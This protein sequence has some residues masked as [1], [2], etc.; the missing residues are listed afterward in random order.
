MAVGLL[1]LD[2]LPDPPDYGGEL[3]LVVE[4]LGVGRVGD[5]L[6]RPDHG[7]RHPAVEGG[8]LV[9]LVRYR[10]VQPAE[11]VLEV[12]LEAEEVPQGTR[13]QRRE[14]P[15]VLRGAR[16]A[17]RGAGLDKRDHVAVEAGVVDGVALEYPDAR[18][19]PR[20]VGY[21][22]HAPLPSLPPDL[23]AADAML[24]ASEILA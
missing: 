5:D 3:Q 24:T 7:V 13:P 8:H 18:A 23:L 17:D 22:L 19:P 2:V 20:F 4:L 10:P 14:Q 16:L 21:E 6:P 15:G 1:S 12:P 9:P 11:G